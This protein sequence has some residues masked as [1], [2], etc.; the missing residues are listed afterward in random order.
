MAVQ[1]E[2]GGVY[3]RIMFENVG[4]IEAAVRKLTPERLAEFRAWFA[5]F[6]AELWDKQFERDAKAG[7]LDKFADEALSD[8]R[9]GRCKDL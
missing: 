9:E 4:E 8:L 3:N 7:R 1:S 6:D 2:G 5:T